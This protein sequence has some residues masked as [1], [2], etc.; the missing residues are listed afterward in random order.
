MVDAVGTPT[1]KSVMLFCEKI[2]GNTVSDGKY[3]R[4]IIDILPTLATSLFIGLRSRLNVG[5]GI[6]LEEITSNPTR[7][8]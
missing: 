6:L 1:L 2:K 3:K 8:R 5:L 7:K 4:M